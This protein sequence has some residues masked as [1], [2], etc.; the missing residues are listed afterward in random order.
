MEQFNQLLPQGD[1]FVLYLLEYPAIMDRSLFAVNGG[2]IFALL[3]LFAG[4]F[5]PTESQIAKF[6]EAIALGGLA[7]IHQFSLHLTLWFKGCIP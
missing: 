5:S 7:E 2:L 1:R 3:T 4:V 6:R